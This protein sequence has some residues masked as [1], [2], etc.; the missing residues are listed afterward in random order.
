[1]ND[2]PVRRAEALGGNEMRSDFFGLLARRLSKYAAVCESIV[3][4]R[5]LHE[6]GLRHADKIPT[7]TTER[8]LRVLY[9]L[10][11]QC[12]TGAT[13]LE[14]GSHYGA[15]TCYLVAGLLRRGGH[16]YCADTWQNDAMPGDRE[17][18]YA[19]FLKNVRP[20][21]KALTPIR[22]RSE[23]LRAEEIPASLHLVFIDADHSYD[24]VRV[25]F[26]LA[27][28]VLSDQGVIAFHDFGNR[29]YDGVTRVVAE[30]LASGGWLIAG[31]VDTLVWIK[32]NEQ[33]ARPAPGH[34]RQQ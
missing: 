4:S 8:E 6:V 13:A 33:A 23:H 1:M 34:R 20:V 11:S 28:S 3:V 22:I 2:F 24:A 9:H 16:L 29:D 31:F 12:P 10:A 19:R 30:A 32:R 5:S 14:I 26:V 7:F 27:E 18:T 15:S 17:D 25:D 21:R